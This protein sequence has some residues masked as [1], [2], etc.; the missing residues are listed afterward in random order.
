M[1]RLLLRLEITALL[2]GAVCNSRAQK[3]S[4]MQKQKGL[5][6]GVT[7]PEGGG[8]G[9]SRGRGLTKQRMYENANMKLISLYGLFKNSLKRPYILA[10]SNAMYHCRYICSL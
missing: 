3:S 7:G 5:T 10:Y 1:A 9:Q 4:L 8:R 2:C 6:G